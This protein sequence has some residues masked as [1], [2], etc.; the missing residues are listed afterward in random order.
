M[1]SSTLPFSSL[2]RMRRP[3]ASCTVL[4]CSR[5]RGHGATTIA[6]TNFASSPIIEYAELVLTTAARATT[7]RSGA[8][9]SRIAQL[10]VVDCLFVAVAQRSYDKTMQALENTYA[11]VRGRRYPLR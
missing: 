8:T 9:A 4:A 2:P 6:V 10:A 5:P 3:P 1:S 7:F 11:A